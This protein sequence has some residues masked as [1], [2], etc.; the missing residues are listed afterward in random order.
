MPPSLILDNAK[1]SHTERKTQLHEKHMKP[2]TKTETNNAD[3]VKY[4]KLLSLLDTGCTLTASK[5]AEK[6]RN[7]YKL[8]GFVIE[9]ENS[10]EVC[11]CNRSAGRWLKQKEMEWLMLVSESPLT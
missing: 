4:K 1:R 11:I 10:N 6:L 7:G 9:S 2:N 8:T 3:E 5:V